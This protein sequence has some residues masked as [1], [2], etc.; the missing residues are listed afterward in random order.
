MKNTSL[1]HKGQ[2]ALEYLLL[3][4]LVSIVVFFAF[5]PGGFMTQ[6]RGKSNEYYE[7]VARVIMGENPAPINGGWCSPSASGYRTCECPAPAFGGQ[8]CG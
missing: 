3:L 2:S 6:V 8:P 7:K 4:G 1:R 5:A